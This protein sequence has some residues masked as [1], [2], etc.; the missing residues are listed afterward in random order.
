MKRR[1][2]VL[3]LLG[4]LLIVAFEHAFVF[5]CMHYKREVLVN[6]FPKEPEEEGSMKHNESNSNACERAR[7]HYE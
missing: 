4:T 5:G 2:S 7:L 3:G 6:V 1:K